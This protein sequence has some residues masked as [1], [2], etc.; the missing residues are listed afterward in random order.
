VQTGR[1]WRELGLLGIHYAWTSGV[2]FACL[3]PAQA[4]AYLLLAQA[5]PSAA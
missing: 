2:A 1:G 5:R 3:A 4:V